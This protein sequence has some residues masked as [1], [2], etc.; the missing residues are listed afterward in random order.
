MPTPPLTPRPTATLFA[1]RV[2]V[3][4]MQLYVMSG[5]GFATDPDQANKGQVNGLCGAAVPGMLFLTTGLHTGATHLTIEQ[6]DEEPA[7]DDAWEEIVEVSFRPDDELVSLVEW[8]GQA[9]YPFLLPVQYYRV[10]Y[11]AT[12]MDAASAA[13]VVTGDEPPLDRYLLQL[14]PDFPQP[15]RIRRQTADVAAY[16]HQAWRD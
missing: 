12:G 15:D 13:D 8:A 7:L 14:W 1:G 9:S 3:A 16:W 4:Y 2:H 10:R 5:S 6:Y 11:C